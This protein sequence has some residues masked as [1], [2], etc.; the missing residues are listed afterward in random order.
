MVF[1]KQKKP[2]ILREDERSRLSSLKSS[3][4]EP[5]VQ[6]VRAKILLEYAQEKPINRIA[7]EL[8]VSRN[9]I[10]RCINKALM[11][12][13]ELALSDLPRPGKPSTIDANDKAWVVYI[14]CTKPQKIGY[15]HELWTIDLL[16]RHVR[17]HAHK[18]GHPS[19]KKAGKS[20][21]HK[22]LK[23]YAIRPHKISYY[24]ERKDPEFEEKMARVLCVYKEVQEINEHE[25]TDM[26]G[27]K[28]VTFSYDEKPGIQA[29][30]QI[31]P[32]LPPTIEK[33]P[34]MARDYEYK[35]Q[36]TI[37]LLAGI[38]L[39][40]GRVSG[41]VCDRHRSA[42]FIEFL[43]LLDGEYPADWKLRLILDNHSAHTSKE[44]LSWLKKHPNRFEFVFTPKHGSWL[45]IIETFFSKMTRTFLCGIRVKSKDELK[46]R[47]KDYL[48]FVNESPVVF[49]W[50]YRLDE[51]I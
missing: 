32:D 43:S 23:E 33:Y 41:L 47:L 16:A 13:I 26:S 45:N 9:Q 27:N 15:P 44:T 39:H 19:L 36:G 35:R 17:K 25:E 51:L 20:T 1:Q 5:Y 30:S 24:L 46:S 14:A 28:V 18:T 42:E 12:G 11:G 50:K 31:S 48:N 38:N 7:R 34:T 22:I 10:E 4:K 3:G 6:V 49:R 29:L 40:N 37:S 2:L 8:K 21:I